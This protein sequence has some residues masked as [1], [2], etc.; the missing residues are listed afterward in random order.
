MD[1]FNEKDRVMI[2]TG[3]SAFGGAGGLIGFYITSALPKYSL[4]IASLIYGALGILNSFSMK[5][6]PLKTLRE[7]RLAPKLSNLKSV[8]RG[9]FLCGKNICL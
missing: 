8:L 1:V 7:Q 9:Q 6:I 5:E 2:M 4:T 3:N